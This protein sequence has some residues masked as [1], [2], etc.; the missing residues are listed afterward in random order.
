MKGFG[1]ETQVPYV[2]LSPQIEEDGLTF[3]KFTVSYFG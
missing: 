1:F 3:K 2:Y